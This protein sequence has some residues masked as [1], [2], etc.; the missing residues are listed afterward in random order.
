MRDNM[1]LTPAALFT[2]SGQIIGSSGANQP[3]VRTPAAATVLT[4]QTTSST[5]Y[6][7]LATVGP[8]VAA[9]TGAQALASLAVDMTC[10][11]TG[12]YSAAAIAVSGA[13]TIAGTDANGIRFEPG[14]TNGVSRNGAVVMFS[15]A[16]SNALTPGSNTFTIKYRIQAGTDVGTFAS[17][18]L[19]V[20]PL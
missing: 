10:N 2:G 15:A 13:T 16:T 9:T 17:R 1:L 20:L 19:T 6:T 14:T 7:D 5:S 8:Q 11:V 3:V 4:S 18:H 12:H